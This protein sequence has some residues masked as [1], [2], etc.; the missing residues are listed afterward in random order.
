VCRPQAKAAKSCRSCGGG[1]DETIEACFA[2]G[3]LVLVAAVALA[4]LVFA[5]RTLAGPNREQAG[6]RWTLERLNGHALAGEAPLTLA[7]ESSDRLGGHSGCNQFGADFQAQ[8]DALTVGEIISTR[9]ACLDEGLNSQEVEYQQALSSPARYQIDG[10][11]LTLFDAQGSV[12]LVFARQ[13]GS[14]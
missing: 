1:W 13:T 6:S 11:R 9:M 8:G 14:K 3:G 5:A 10:D 12:S 2:V 7:F 4:A